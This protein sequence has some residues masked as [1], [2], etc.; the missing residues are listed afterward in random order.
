MREIIA[1]TLMLINTFDQ[2]SRKA[3]AYFV[4]K[5]QTFMTEGTQTYALCYNLKTSRMV[6]IKVDIGESNIRFIDKDRQIPVEK[7]PSYVEYQRED[8]E[9]GKGYFKLK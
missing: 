3:P 6:F 7:L 1:K 4:Y 2:P 8:N 9:L 5:G